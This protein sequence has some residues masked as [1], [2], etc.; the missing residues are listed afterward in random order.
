VT[1]TYAATLTWNYNDVTHE[2]F[3][4]FRRQ[5]GTGFIWQEIQRVDKSTLRYVDQ[6]DDRLYCYYIKAYAGTRIS[7]RSNIACMK[8]STPEDLIIQE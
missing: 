3:I 4:I 8:V 1:P 2:G 6:H 5:A 7:A